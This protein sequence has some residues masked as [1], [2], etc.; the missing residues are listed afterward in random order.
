MAARKREIKHLIALF[1]FESRRLHGQMAAS[2]SKVLRPT[3]SPTVCLSCFVLGLILIIVP[4]CVYKRQCLR[5]YEWEAGRDVHLLPQTG[6]QL[7]FYLFDFFFTEYSA[8]E[9]S[10]RFLP[11]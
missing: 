1:I 6:A 5:L 10:S 8:K 2:F 7:T 3:F 9:K 11:D 4:V